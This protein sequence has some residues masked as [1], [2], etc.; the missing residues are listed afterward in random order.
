MP[1]RLRTK[2]RVLAS[3]VLLMSLALFILSAPQEAKE[4][5]Q[6]AGSPPTGSIIKFSCPRAWAATSG[7]PTPEGLEW[8][9]KQ[10]YRAV[11]NFRTDQEGVDIAA[12]ANH[13]RQLG[14]NYIHIPAPFPELPDEAVDKFLA[15]V[16]DPKN[17]PVYIHCTTANR[18]GA[19]WM[20]YLV[21]KEGLSVEKAQE[22]AAG[23]GLKNQKLI[24]AA[25]NYLSRHARP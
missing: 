13:A 19:F 24:D 1:K 5:G 2:A 22:E 4:A 16:A 25:R 23:V 15:A 8:I 3:L 10:G 14:M 9:A 21:T 12:E 20:I 6:K 11:I 17:R 18:V 7:Q